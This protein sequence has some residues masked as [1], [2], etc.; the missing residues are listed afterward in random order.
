MSA[1]LR[2]PKLRKKKVK[3]SIYWFSEAGGTP[4]YFGRVGEV[5]FD[6]ARQAFRNHLKSL[7]ETGN[8]RKG[9]HL[10]VGELID[11]FLDWV[12]QHRS[13]ATYF[14]RRI[15]CSTFGA[16]KTGGLRYLPAAKVTS[17]DLET[18]LRQFDETGLSNQPRRHAETSVR[19][20]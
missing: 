13:H 4:T 10:M 11:L 19:H 9:H 2:E 5:S 15:Y 18:F 8:G 6:D 16:I 1:R 7:D 12:Q 14:T 20:C 17:A 3:S